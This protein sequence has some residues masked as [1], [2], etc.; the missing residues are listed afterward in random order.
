MLG[1]VGGRGQGPKLNAAQARHRPDSRARRARSGESQ[2]RGRRTAR[3]GKST[4]PLATWFLAL[5]FFHHH[6]HSS[7]FHSQHTSLQTLLS[8]VSPPPWPECARAEADL[9]PIMLLALAVV[10]ARSF[11]LGALALASVVT[12]VPMA[13]GQS[14]SGALVARGEEQ[15]GCTVTVTATA[16]AGGHASTG[17]AK[18]TSTKKAVTTKKT[19]TR[20][21]ATTK[22]LTTTKAATTAAATTKSKSAASSSASGSS[23]S[24]GSKGSKDCNSSASSAFSSCS[25]K[26]TEITTKIKS[27]C[28]ASAGTSVSVGGEVGALL[29]GLVG[30]G[31]KVSGGS[32]V[33]IDA[34]VQV[35]AV[36]KL[37]AEV[38]AEVSSLSGTLGGLEGYVQVEGGAT[39]STVGH[40]ATIFVAD[41]NAL[42]AALDAHAS[43]SGLSAVSASFKAS[44]QTRV[45]GCFSV[46]GDVVS[47]VAS[48]VASLLGGLGVSAGLSVSV[49]AGL[50]VSI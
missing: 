21:A 4:K 10:F 29:G 7:L 15:C 18:T 38:T 42:Y 17:K 9:T 5:G 43:I 41:L 25:G 8:K 47:G 44:V 46:L 45:H 19:T 48:V 16:T 50:G 20:K 37:L 14:P 30:W 40:A 36:E 22:A 6:R 12:A 34:S 39:V 31:G 11:T 23:S 28:G 24:S 32:S 13:K 49:G 35:E 27:I 2:P 33:A 26:I 1:T 3:D